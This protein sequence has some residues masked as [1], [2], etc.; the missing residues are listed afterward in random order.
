MAAG[1]DSF[2][3]QTFADANFKYAVDRLTEGMV[4]GI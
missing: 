3:I 4:P 2:K 1:S